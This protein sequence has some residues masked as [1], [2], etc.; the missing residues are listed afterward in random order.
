MVEI[1]PFKPFVPARVKYLIIGSFPG[2]IHTQQKPSNADWFYGSKRNT[3][4][5]ILEEV[6]GIPLPDRSSKQELFT[7]LKMGIADIILKAVRKEGTNADTNLHIIEYNDAAIKKILRSNNFTTI[8]FT[9]KFVEKIFIKLLPGFTNRVVLPS[10][11]P[12][13]ATM[14]LKE[15]IEVYKKLLPKL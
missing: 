9:G 1:H 13:F 2:K 14:S 10:P 11:S 8:F 3:F 7:K 4:W 12:R 6:Y 5:K 15:K